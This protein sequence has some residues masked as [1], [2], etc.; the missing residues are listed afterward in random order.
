MFQGIIER[1]TLLL[2]L[3]ATTGAL[4]LNVVGNQSQ[5]VLL[6]C[7]FRPPINFSVEH[8]VINWQ[9][10]EHNTILHSFYDMSDHP[11]FQHD[12]FKG[13]TKLFQQEFSK[14][15]ASLFL[16]AIT[17]LDSGTYICL[18]AVN[19]KNDFTINEVTLKVQDLKEPDQSETWDTR[20]LLVLLF[21]SLLAVAIYVILRR[22]KIH[23]HVTEEGVPLISIKDR[24]IEMY[25]KSILNEYNMIDTT[26]IISRD[27]DIVDPK[28]LASGTSRELMN[29]NM[30]ME[31]EPLDDFLTLKQCPAG[32]RI[33][34]I[35]DAGGGKSCIMKTMEVV[36]A[37]ET[38]L[39]DTCI[40][41]FSCTV[42]NSVKALSVKEFLNLKEIPSTLADALLQNPDR[43]IITL[44]GLDEFIH[45]LNLQSTANTSDTVSFT[46]TLQIG[47]LVSKIIKKELLPQASVIVTSRR[48]FD[49]SLPRWFDRCVILPALNIKEIKV[50]C[51][52]FCEDQKMS[53]DIYRQVIE[54]ETL[55][56]LASVPLHSYF[57]CQL[58]KTNSKMLNKSNTCSSVFIGYISSLVS[59]TL[60]DYADT[61]EEVNHLTIN[62]KEEKI[63]KCVEKLGKLCL[64]TLNSGQLRVNNIDMR[65]YGLEPKVLEYFSNVLLKKKNREEEYFEFSHGV[66]KELF[67][68]SYFVHSIENDDELIAALNTLL[69]LKDSMSGI[70]KTK[71]DFQLLEDMKTK[72]YTLSRLFMGVLAS[73]TDLFCQTGSDISENR[74]KLLMEWFQE[75][76]PKYTSEDQLNL[77]HC[78]FELQDKHVTFHVSTYIKEVDLLNTPL[79][80]VD[81]IA[82]SYSLRQCKL[83]RLDLRL[84]EIGD[85]GIQQLKDVIANSK[86]VRISA[87]KLTDKS[88]KVIGHILKLKDCNVEELS[89][90]TNN[91]QSSGACKIWEALEV[92][93]SLKTLY[94]H[95]NNIAD[96]GTEQMKRFLSKNTRLVKINLCGNNFSTRGL[97]NITDIRNC[98]KIEIATTITED[99]PFFTF[100][101]EKVDTL[102]AEIKQ[103]NPG[104]VKT[105]LEAVKKDL[106]ENISSEAQAL[107]V[108][109]KHLLDEF[110]QSP[111][112]VV[113]YEHS[114]V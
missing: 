110:N 66:F 88:A 15:N 73:Q 36:W 112:P 49:S 92:N 48:N 32:K 45:M 7:T 52:S 3:S 97:G 38:N 19:E 29:Y 16:M 8:L 5:N 76:I 105:C 58:E 71:N 55:S 79:S 83:D 41:N 40:L 111:V 77:L 14:G 75:R 6:P 80:S 53:N 54:D 108:K 61:Q 28:M 27:L 31:K 78:L 20:L 50:F 23:M 57:M 114:P 26:R 24:D 102:Q 60:K 59:S 104:W 9:K 1:L 82:L 63:I 74:K 64:E 90:G 91:L 2:T 18:T 98:T 12:Q 51:E 107:L 86:D 106:E 47:D 21:P 84:C 85:E 67:A 56:C 13:R 33:L 17:P 34:L 69:F 96:E 39:S 46:D 93:K 70:S 113:Q 87:N 94:L 99:K 35:A 11:D 109:I 44:D 95:H 65:K 62:E 89:I 101:Q 68:A 37:K 10:A 22:R 25:K 100:V 43:I 4:I 42:L 81:V 30:T 72:R 103:Y